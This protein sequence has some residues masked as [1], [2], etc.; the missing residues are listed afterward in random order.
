[1]QE[2]WNKGVES[3][4]SFQELYK[5]T[6]T[7]QRSFPH[8]CADWKISI[9][10]CELDSR[11]AL[12]FRDRLIIPTLEHLQ[13]A[14]IQKAHDSHITGHPGRD[15]TF[16]I[17]RRD[18]HWPGMSQMVRRFCRNCDVCG[19]S[20]L[21][22]ERRKGLL[23]P[24]PVPDRFYSELSI[25]FMTELPQKTSEDPRY[26]MVICD[27]LLKSVT[28]EAMTTMDADRCA[29]T[30]VQ[31]HFRFHGFPR[32]ITSDRGS[33]WTSDFWT[34][35]C[36]LVKIDRRLST[37]FHPETD[38]TTERANQEV[39]AY[40]RAFV[41]YSQYDW[42]KLLPMAMLALNNRQ[43]ST[44]TSPF[45]L[46][47]GFHLDPIQQ[48]EHKD[49]S[50]SSRRAEVF[51]E[52]LREGQ[53]FA[54]AAMATAQQRMED[55]ANNHRQPAIMFKV[56]DRVW[57]NLKNIQTPQQSKKLSWLNAKYKIIKVVSPHV[58]ELDVPTGIHPRF[59]VDL[60]KIA[61]TDPLPSQQLDDHQPPP[62]SD[63]GAPEHFVQRICRSRSKKVGRGYQRQVLVKWEG[64][65]DLT[66]EPRE[67]FQST[68][69]LDIFEQKFGTCDDVGEENTGPITGPKLRRN[70]QITDKIPNIKPIHRRKSKRLNKKLVEKDAVN[71]G[72][73]KVIRKGGG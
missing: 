4:K 69:A 65:R 39:Q 37:A 1:M 57:L 53:D 71:F 46:T 64:Y 16:A 70:R 42:P 47:H 36:E 51:I 63:F 29:E 13:T 7:G 28:L 58:V 62:M 61:G 49:G 56:G 26:L 54:Q 19:R 5:A 73:V 48:V 24:L 31:C 27:R 11:G 43:N 23:R 12:K 32:F 66:W 3:D 17:L 44:G 8:S 20:H 67:E 50:R 72:F 18:F 35:L 38:G 59:H 60:L 15:S 33:N 30:F 2:L 10:E 45:F 68:V 55:S 52:R 21:W 6:F 14:L 34:R 40:L 41:T 22:R 9:A 25:D